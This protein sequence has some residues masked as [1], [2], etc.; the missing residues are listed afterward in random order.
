VRHGSCAER[1]RRCRDLPGNSRER[2]ATDFFSGREIRN[3]P[4]VG[5]VTEEVC[6]AG[7]VAGFRDVR[8]SFSVQFDRFVKHQIWCR[9][10]CNFCLFSS[11]KF[12]LVNHTNLV[13][14]E[15]A[16]PKC[17]VGPVFMRAWGRCSLRLVVGNQRFVSHSGLGGF[18]GRENDFTTR[19]VDQTC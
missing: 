9:R 10:Q 11:L 19:I 16:S 8:H 18:S 17:F 4:V 12:W 7:C 3:S 15:G 1:S 5:C 14:T 13:G 2:F 6:H